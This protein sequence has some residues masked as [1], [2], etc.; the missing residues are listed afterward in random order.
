MDSREQPPYRK[1][2]KH[3]HLLRRRLNGM[4]GGRVR[5]G[6]RRGSGLKIVSTLVFYKVQVTPMIST[7]SGHPSGE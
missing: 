3:T 7:I 6:I 1:N 4:A 5:G 2:N